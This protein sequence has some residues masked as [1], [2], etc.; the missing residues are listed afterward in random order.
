MPSWC[1]TKRCGKKSSAV[2]GA[3]GISRSRRSWTSWD[4]DGI[5]RLA[6]GHE[7]AVALLAAEGEIGAGL[8]QEDLAD[9]LAI[10]REDL[11]AVIAG[12]HPAR[13]DPDIAVDVDAH[14][15]REA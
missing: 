8:G 15:V 5:E 10:R 3:N 2:S 9:P 14:A 7:Q 13:A 1:R 11:H 6:R 12:S 4:R